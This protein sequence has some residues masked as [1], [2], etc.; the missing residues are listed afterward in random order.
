[1][2]ATNPQTGDSKTGTKVMTMLEAINDAMKV[3]MRNDDR[4]VVFGEDVGKKGFEP[5]TDFVIQ[6]RY[7]NLSLTLALLETISVSIWREKI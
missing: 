2:T 7:L 5:L 6:R 4:V 1:M 3:E